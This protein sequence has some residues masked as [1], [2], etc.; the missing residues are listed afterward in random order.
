MASL[1]VRKLD[2]DTMDKLRARAAQHGISMEEEVRR[3]IRLAVSSPDRLGDFAVDL[4]SPAYGESDFQLPP[5][6]SSEPM[7]F[8]E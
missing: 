8:P 2:D 4:F 6:E 7:S 1:S 3:I 5:R